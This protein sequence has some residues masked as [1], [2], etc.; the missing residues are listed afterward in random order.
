MK[1]DFPLLYRCTHIF[2]SILLN[3]GFNPL[4]YFMQI[5]TWSL[6]N[7]AS[8]SQVKS[9]HLLSLRALIYRMEINI[10]RLDAERSHVWE[11]ACSFKFSVNV[12]PLYFSWFCR[13]LPSLSF[14]LSL[15][16]VFLFLSLLPI[17]HTHTAFLRYNCN[18]L[19]IFMYLKCK[20]WWLLNCVYTHETI[21]TIKLM[22][23]YPSIIPQSYLM[24]IVMPPSGASHFLPITNHQFVFCHYTL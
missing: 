23:R 1:Q 19:Y 21:T 3:A 2:L 9:R 16:S 4:N 17:I 20:I 12:V 24:S 14:R 6:N 8:R 18:K 5:V 13:T 10:H 7:T 15:F 22:S 11:L